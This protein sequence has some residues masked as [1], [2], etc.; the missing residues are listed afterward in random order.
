MEH[1][2]RVDA[3]FG[4][5]RDGEVIVLPEV[6]PVGI[7]GDYDGAS[8]SHRATVESLKDA[9]DLVG[10]PVKAT[11]IPTPSLEESPADVCDGFHALW[12]APGGP[13]R[14]MEG[15]LNGIRFAREDEIPFLGTCGGFQHTVIEYA[16]NVLGFP[17]AGHEEYDPLV[18]DPFISS[19]SCSPAGK[20]MRVEIKADSI[21]GTIYGVTESNEEYRCNF[22]ISP[23]RRELLEEGGLRVAGVDDSGEA[24]IL[25]LPGSVFYVATLF[26]PQMNSSADRPHPLVVEL[27]R[28]A[29]R[30]T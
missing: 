25:E 23:G 13:Y 21:A 20:T 2:L 12:C 14:S 5:D 28:A 8:L 1:G 10:T 15:A 11:W 30:R 24:R 17:E 16:R 27:V 9:A 22:G 6:L 4:V 18:P 3:G 19:L 26:L 29:L 7:I